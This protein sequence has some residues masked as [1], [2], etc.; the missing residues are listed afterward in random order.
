MRFRAM[1]RQTLRKKLIRETLEKRRTILLDELRW[2]VL[3]REAADGRRTLERMERGPMQS[4]AR[5][6]REHMPEIAAWN[7]P[8]SAN[9]DCPVGLAAASAV[10]RLQE[11]AEL[12]AFLNG[13]SPTIIAQRMTDLPVDEFGETPRYLKGPERYVVPQYHLLMFELYAEYGEDPVTG[14][15]TCRYVGG[16]RIPPAHKVTVL[17][18]KRR[19]PWRMSHFRFNRGWTLL[20]FS[21]ATPICGM[22]KY[23]PSQKVW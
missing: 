13:P 16:V 18:L 6:V 20:P 14:D 4:F 10:F 12:E 15:R 19:P 2:I 17:G 3:Q 7:V 1:A 5:T 9:S 22:P 23:R 8:L 11:R 21:P